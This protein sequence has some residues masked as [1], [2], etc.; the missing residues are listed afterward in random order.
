MWH[1]DR[2]IP[3]CARG[4]RNPGRN[5]R[6]GRSSRPLRQGGAG[7]WQVMSGRRR[8]DGF[9]GGPFRRPLTGTP[10]RRWRS[11][12]SPWSE[13]GAVPDVLRYAARFTPF[14]PAAARCRAAPGLP[15]VSEI[16]ALPL[17]VTEDDYITNTLER[18][19]S[20]VDVLGLSR[21]FL[22]DQRGLA[23]G[24]VTFDPDRFDLERG[25]R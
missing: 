23:P 9:G 7:D 10:P 25:E 22:L 2:T 18:T 13:G 5:G 16:K 15:L 14:G 3:R 6:D 19:L 11:P 17:E 24:A 12:G 20:R 1:L 8:Q 4:R 21:L